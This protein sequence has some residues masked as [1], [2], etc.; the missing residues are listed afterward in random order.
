MTQRDQALQT[1]MVRAL[2]AVMEGRTLPE[3]EARSAMIAL[4]SGETPIE[5]I[6]AF[7]T[8][9]HFRPPTGEE[10][11]GFVS[12]L[13]GQALTVDLDASVAHDLIDVCG[14]GGD[15]LGSFNVSTCVAFVV[16]A[17][18]QSI[19][20]H[21]NRA[22]SSRCGSFDVLEALEVPFAEDAESTRAM[23]E[24]H[25][26]AF[27]FAPSFHPALK[28][29]APLR[30]NLG[31]R[32]VLNALGPLLNPV[33]V[34]RQLIGVYSDHLLVPMAE[35]LGR[36]GADRALI[37]RGEDGSDEI[38]ISAA[39][40][41]AFL[42]RG[43]I[44]VSQIEPEDFGLARAP[45]T[46]IAGGDPRENAERLRFALSGEPSPCRDIVLLNAAAALMVGGKAVDIRE[47]LWIAAEAID[48]GRAR[49]LL[50]EMARRNASS[51][52]NKSNANVAM[53][54]I[55]FLDE[56]AA[57]TRERVARARQVLPFEELEARARRA[58]TPLNFRARLESSPRPRILAEVKTKSPSQG[59]ILEDGDPVAIAR[60]YAHAGA[61]A[62]SVLT[63]PHRFGGRIENLM[64]IRAELPEMPL[65]M[66]DFV[67]DPYQ[68]FEA[69]VTGADA[70]LL[71]VSLLGEGETARFMKIASDLGLATLVEVHDERELDF[72]LDAG[73]K[74]VGVN[75][76]DLRSL[77]VSLDV[78]RRLARRASAAG[79][80]GVTLVS[81]SGI[82]SREDIL[83][84][85]PLGFDVFLIG[86]R[87][88]REGRPGDALASLRGE[89]VL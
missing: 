37:V 28:R 38:S 78:S 19:A 72:A 1:E 41:M 17:S 80:A 30:R 61:A 35:A 59:V 51:V 26:L 13:R 36:L 44:E 65:L 9:F 4:L 31:F 60:D 82:E 81:E 77:S 55:P 23:L 85:E 50:K 52:S 49:T 70:V 48:S 57:L 29:L 56:I 20:K 25:G 7:L 10:L 21:G 75:N 15:G 68:I 18:G 16:A 74:L 71:I 32:T 33:G 89:K 24:A 47:G 5:Q 83:A 84:L 73:A 6:A 22:V 2:K 27:L 66:K 45:V 69:R 67:L 46:T 58:R 53:S 62:I 86:T 39:T 42:D 76:R 3:A 43:R 54:S 12:A 79:V 34:R 40:R 8:S 88:T 87:L 11:A 64:R 14:T 63:E